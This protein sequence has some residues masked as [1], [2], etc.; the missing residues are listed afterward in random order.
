MRTR[1]QVVLDENV[2]RRFKEELVRRGLKKGGLSEEIEILMRK[3]LDKVESKTLLFK[4]KD[5]KKI[6]FLG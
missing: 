5:I 3:S 4:Q 1:I 2:E 6:V